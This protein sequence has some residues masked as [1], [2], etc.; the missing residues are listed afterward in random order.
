MIKWPHTRLPPYLI[1]YT[2]IRDELAPC[3]GVDLHGVAGVWDQQL[4]GEDWRDGLW[5]TCLGPSLFFFL[6][7]AVIQ[8]QLSAFSPHPSTPPQPNPPPS[9][10]S[11]LPLGSLLVSGTQHGGLLSS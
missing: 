2:S 3:A 9:P 7:F 1:K 6:I 4:G 10:A 8:L 5:R 11:T